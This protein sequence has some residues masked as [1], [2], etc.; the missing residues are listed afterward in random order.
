[1]YLLRIGRLRRWSLDRDAGRPEDV[2]EAARDLSL[3]VGEAGLSV[4]RVEDEDETREV[5]V[6]FALTCRPKPQHLDFVV[7][8]SELVSHLGL[9]IAPVPRED[10]E[11]FLSARHHE[12]AGLTP[13]LALHLAAAILG[14]VGRQVERIREH[15]LPTLGVESCRRDPEL[16]QFLKGHWAMLLSRVSPGDEGSEGRSLLTPPLT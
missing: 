3:D 1:V 13:V 6:R 7:F 4:F 10:L 15:D 14:C 16:K 11:P 5:V 8:P 2:A 9:D 12:I